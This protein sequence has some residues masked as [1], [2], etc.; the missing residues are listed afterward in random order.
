LR[1]NLPPAKVYLGDAGS[2]LIGLVF[3]ALAI[4][5]S[6]KQ[7]TA[8][9][10]LG[11][12]ALLSIPF[13]DTAAAII[14]RRL[15][16]RSIYSVDRAHLHHSLAGHGY[17]PRGSLVLVAVLSSL[18]ALGGTLSIITKESEYAAAAIAIVLLFLVS[19]RLFGFVELKLVVNKVIALAS[20]LK[21]LRSRTAAINRSTAV[22]LQGRRDWQLIWQ[23]IREFA[24]K[25]DF[26]MVK[27]HLHLPWLHEFFHARYDKAGADKIDKTDDWYFVIPICIGKRLA[28]EIDVIA[29]K[30]RELVPYEVIGQMMEMLADLEPEFLEIM[31]SHDA[32]PQASGIEK[33]RVRVGET[34]TAD[35][36]AMVEPKLAFRRSVPAGESARG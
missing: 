2:M 9:A 24:E 36:D 3:A 6:F 12:L 30:N 27:M 28:G 19:N 16:G 7:A 35:E 31:Q 4:R 29:L 22:Q 33:V 21:S 11:P 32:Q 10:F 5:C 14:R 15:T 25:H 34:Q 23:N 20:S 1:F 13:V 17:G 18:T 8:Y 26:K